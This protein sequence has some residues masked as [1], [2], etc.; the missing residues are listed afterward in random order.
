M[1]LTPTP[2]D[3]AGR[4]AAAVRAVWP[5]T[6]SGESIL[7]NELLIEDVAYDAEER[8]PGYRLASFRTRGWE[9]TPGTLQT[10][11]GRLLDLGWF[12]YGEPEGDGP[13]PA[14]AFAVMRGLLVEAL[15]DPDHE[16][17]SMEEPAAFWRLDGRSVEMHCFV[18]GLSGL[19]I[20]V[21]HR[22]RAA[23]FETRTKP[24]RPF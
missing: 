7:L 14:E 8:E 24:P 9:E 17:G 13:R 23:D 19:Q 16:W 11:R 3:V 4:V 18:K 2:D 15:G 5:E 12:L 20:N 21:A 22:P 6:E 1:S 10:W